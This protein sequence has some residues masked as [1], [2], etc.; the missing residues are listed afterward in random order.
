V[1]EP[2]V[3]LNGLMLPSYEAHLAVFDMGIV[4][5]ATVVEQSRTFEQK[6][7]RLDDHLDRLF[8]S[9]E[10]AGLQIR[11]SK[12]ELVAISEELVAH[13]SRFLAPGDDLGLIHFVTAGQHAVYAG[14]PV[15]TSATVCAHTF[16]LP[17]HLWA[18]KMESGAHLITPSIRQVPAEC[19]DPHMKCRS[20]MHY[21]LAEKEVQAIDPESS[22]LLLDLDGHV[23]ETSAANFMIVAEDIILSPP[24]GNIL[25]GISRKTVV[26]LAEQSGISMV[27]K[28]I[29]LDDVARAG[30]AF[31]S[32]T[33]FCLMPVTKV[34]DFTI[35]DGK[36]GRV[37]RR[38]ADAWSRR[39]GLDILTQIK[40]VAKCRPRS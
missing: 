25:D 38:L 39:V 12:K 36:P 7:F 20:R 9:L 33:G 2:L 29:G 22:A 24:L 32:S 37:F 30:E 23:A 4:M 3:Y 26:E 40:E 18:K 6:L 10:I 17:F 11:L 1:A 13:N 14:G 34:N 8:G 28:E 15:R 35:G 19:Y 21:F 16:P 31:L 27:E 5:G